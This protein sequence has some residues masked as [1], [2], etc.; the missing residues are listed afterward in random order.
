M[1][2]VGRT[3]ARQAT[4][5]QMSEVSTEDTRDVVR[6]VVLPFLIER[7]AI[8]KFCHVDNLN[9]AGD[10]EGEYELGAESRRSL[11]ARACARS[12]R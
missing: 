3:R 4:H 9:T 12:T 6:R 5:R 8:L 1:G 2:R 7:L 11:G 10:G